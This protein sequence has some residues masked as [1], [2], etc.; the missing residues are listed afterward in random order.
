MYTFADLAKLKGLT[1]RQAQKLFTD[2]TDMVL[3]VKINDK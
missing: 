2:S 1:V 3:D